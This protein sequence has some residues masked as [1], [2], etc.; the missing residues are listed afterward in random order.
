M[1]S[2]LPLSK[3]WRLMLGRKGLPWRSW[4]VIT[5]R[6]AGIFWPVFFLWPYVRVVLG[7][8]MNP[9]RR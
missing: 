3:R 9:N 1:D 7:G 8:V 2:A 5:R 4:W 6:H